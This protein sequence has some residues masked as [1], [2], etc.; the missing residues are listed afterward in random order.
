MKNTEKQKFISAKIKKT[1]NEGIHGKKVKP[2]QAAAV[3][4]SC[5]K[6]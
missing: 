2:A 5:L 1:M 6:K 3:A 4:Y